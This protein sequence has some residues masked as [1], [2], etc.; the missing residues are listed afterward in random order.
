[1]SATK[2]PAKTA[3]H[4]RFKDLKA[5]KNPKGGAPTIMN[6]PSVMAD[7]NIGSAST[8]GGGGKAPSVGSITVTKTTD[9]SSADLFKA[10]LGGG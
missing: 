10:C 1:M 3:A 8:G 4:G 5:K 6:D 7:L 9:S 2:K